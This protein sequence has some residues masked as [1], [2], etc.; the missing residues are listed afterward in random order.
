LE[1][2]DANHHDHELNKKGVEIV[3]HPPSTRVIPEWARSNFEHHN[4]IAG[5]LGLPGWEVV[6]MQNWK[7]IV[8]WASIYNMMVVPLYDMFLV[9]AVNGVCIFHSF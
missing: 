4:N 7:Y 9:D 1:E 2:S 6:F 3:L 8:G 5:V